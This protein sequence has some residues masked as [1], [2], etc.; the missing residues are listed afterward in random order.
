MSKQSMWPEV[1]F[2]TETKEGREMCIKILDN[3][4][5]GKPKINR[6]DGKSQPRKVV[7]LK[8]SNDIE[9]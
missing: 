2:P 5:D 7:K 4:I 3:Y 1:Y 6:I 8:E 9:L